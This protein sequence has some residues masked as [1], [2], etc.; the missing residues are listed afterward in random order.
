MQYIAEPIRERGFTVLK[1][2]NYE[3][4]NLQGMSMKNLHLL[5]FYYF[6]PEDII[7][8]HTKEFQS[9]PRNPQEILKSKKIFDYVESMAFAVEI[10]DI[11]SAAVWYF[12]DIR[13]SVKVYSEN[14][15]IWR[16]TYNVEW[17]IEALQ[18]EH[19]IYTPSYLFNRI[20]Y[21]LPYTPW[22]VYQFGYIE[23]LP[24][25]IEKHN[26]NDIID[27]IKKKRCFEDFQ[28][29]LNSKQKIA[30]ENQWYH[31]RTR[32]P[33]ESFEKYEEMHEGEVDLSADVEEKVVSEDMVQSFM[34]TLDGKDRKI[35][36]LRMEGCTY[37]KI[38]DEL[39]YKTHSAVIKRI[40]RI[41]E[42][43]Q[44]FAKVDI[45]FE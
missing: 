13:A 41:G 36:T 16:L 21:D 12:L 45:G 19:Y 44:K 1:I 37:E 24:M 31:K 2:Y 5:P 33:Q 11:I 26:L 43:Y 40:K 18:K 23:T 29:R 30:F 8:A 20:D 10:C 38:A 4:E 42:A 15:P 7:K 22:T 39:G 17:Y 3:G 32:H 25:V 35:L 14:D 28:E 9:I 34:D 27:C 6:L